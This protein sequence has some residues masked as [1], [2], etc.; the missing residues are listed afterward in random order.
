MDVSGQCHTLAVLYSRERTASTLWIAGWVSLRAGLGEEA[1]G[2]NSLS[3]L[4]I[5]PRS[6]GMYS[7]TILTELLQLLIVQ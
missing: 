7:N 6:S 3:L 2:K 1:R 4:G 5:K